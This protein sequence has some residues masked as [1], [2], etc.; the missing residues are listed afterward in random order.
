MD[1]FTSYAV[2]GF[3]SWGTTK[4]DKSPITFLRTDGEESRGPRGTLLL[5]RGTFEGGGCLQISEG[6]NWRARQK[7]ESAEEQER[8]QL[9]PATRSFERPIIPA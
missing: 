6:I 4:E 5:G 1:Y 3:R 8:M 7:S 2:G 9:G